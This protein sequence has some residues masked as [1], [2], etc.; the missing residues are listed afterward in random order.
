MK[1]EH[2]RGVR[3]AKKGKKQPGGRAQAHPP[4]LLLVEPGGGLVRE[5]HR[6]PAQLEGPGHALPLRVGLQQRVG[7]RQVIVRQ[8]HGSGWCWKRT[9]CAGREE[10]A[11]AAAAVG[12]VAGSAALRRWL[13]CLLQI[14]WELGRGVRRPR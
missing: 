1:K 2:H 4:V 10:R 5:P 14:S 9:L 12:G 11:V 8:R 13:Y 3:Y 7:G 6:V